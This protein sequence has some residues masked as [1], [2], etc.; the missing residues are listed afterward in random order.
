MFKKQWRKVQYLDN[1][2]WKRWV[3]EYLPRLQHRTKWIDDQRVLLTGFGVNHG[4]N[5]PERIVVHGQSGRRG[6]GTRWQS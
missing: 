6:A 4:Q 5:T 1:L 2:F 3:T